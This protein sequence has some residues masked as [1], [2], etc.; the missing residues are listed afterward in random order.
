MHSLSFCWKEQISLCRAM[1]RD[2]GKN[3]R[4]CLSLTSCQLLCTLPTVY[5]YHYSAFPIKEKG[6]SFHLRVSCV[7]PAMANNEHNRS[8]SN[9]WWYGFSLS[10]PEKE[11]FQTRVIRSGRNSKPD[12]RI[13]CVKGGG[14]KN[15][16]LG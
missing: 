9:R 14:S 6:N 2:I 7:I 3:S 15:S 12:V 10:N 4:H 13:I 8:K 11:D 16:P 1:I 5:V